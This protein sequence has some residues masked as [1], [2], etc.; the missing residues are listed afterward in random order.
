MTYYKQDARIMTY[1]MRANRGTIRVPRRSQAERVLV[2]MEQD[3]QVEFVERHTDGTATYRFKLA[4]KTETQPSES[5]SAGQAEQI[6]MQQLEPA[7]PQ[8]HWRRGPGIARRMV[9]ASGLRR[10]E[11][12]GCWDMPQD[13]AAIL[14]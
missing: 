13:E 6:R 2:R 12:C 11:M 9:S 14:V 4:M 1:Q 5:G 8:Y 10:Q 7:E 3:G